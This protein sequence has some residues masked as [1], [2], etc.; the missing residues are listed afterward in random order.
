MKTFKTMFWTEL[1]LSL[2][3]I[4]LPIFG[5]V[6]PVVLALILGF[7]TGKDTPEAMAGVFASVCS[8]GIAA[9]GLMGIPLTLAGYRNAK[10]LKQLRVTPVWSGLVLLVHVAVK[11]VLAA[12]SALLV[13]LTLVLF[14]QFRPAGNMG[15]FLLAYF[16]AVFAVFGIGM[17]I[18][19]I[20]PNMNTVNLLTSI[21][22][23]PML[24]FSGATIPLHVFPDFV[25]K[26]L[27]VFPLT[28]AIHLLETAAGGAPLAQGAF[29]LA[30][31]VAIGMIS[32]LI[33]VKTFKW[34]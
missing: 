28:Q 21:A 3:H 24:L 8:I 7:V 27:Q 33:S 14:F 5:I 18:A 9:N 13:F 34:E 23:F 20:S 32:V 19:S 4:D 29:S 16:M 11:F 10:I 22:Y 1:K 30:V 31:L 17:I 6:F 25:V 2:R 15:F 26:L 12:V